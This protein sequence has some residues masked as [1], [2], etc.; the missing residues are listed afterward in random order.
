MVVYAKN[1][2]FFKIGVSCE[3]FGKHI[4][5]RPTHRDTHTH[6]MQ[7]CTNIVATYTARMIVPS[8][9]QENRRLPFF[10]FLQQTVAV[11]KNVFFRQMVKCTKQRY[12]HKTKTHKDRECAIFILWPVTQNPYSVYVTQLGLGGQKLPSCI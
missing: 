1:N 9:P 7:T 6:S 4:W 2:A 12:V 8:M 10:D 11:G 5:E 3:K